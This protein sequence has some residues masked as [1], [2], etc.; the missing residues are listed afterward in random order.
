MRWLFG[1]LVLL[2]VGLF[3]WGSWYQKGPV[4]GRLQLRPPVN[5]EKM[6][7]L[8]ESAARRQKPR[9]P[10]AAPTRTIGVTQGGYACVSLGP[11]K[12][13]DRAQAAAGTLERQALG[14]RRREQIERTTVSYRVLLPP[15]QSR[16]AAEKKRQ[17][18]SRLGF[19]E[20]YIIEEPGK[21]N[22]ISLGVFTIRQ[23]AWAL[24]QRLAEK[25]IST[26]QETLQ[27]P[28]TRYWLDLKLGRADLAKLQAL[29]W[30]NVD[31]GLL[32]RS[33]TDLPGKTVGE[34]PAVEQE[35]G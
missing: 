11:F 31:V 27:E 13:L 12:T 23:N 8:T 3:M 18:L 16:A 26:K 7:L 35:P 20:H 22:A 28:V 9:D 29:E 32:E 30:A 19:K 33:C 14:Y 15:L 10:A 6:G 17:Q 2:N 25:G 24:A 34:P 5:A 4:E 1:T 21:E